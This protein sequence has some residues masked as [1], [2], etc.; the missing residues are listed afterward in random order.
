MAITDRDRHDVGLRRSRTGCRSAADDSRFRINHHSQRQARRREGQDIACIRIIEEN[1]LF[2][3][4]YA[5][6]AA[7]GSLLTTPV[8]LGWEQESSPEEAMPEEDELD[9][10][11]VAQA[12]LAGENFYQET[13]VETEKVD[14][15]SIMEAPSFRFDKDMRPSPKTAQAEP[16]ANRKTLIIIPLPEFE[17]ERK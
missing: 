9:E 7:S 2:M 10:E 11:T 15:A 13:I 12:E 6:P 3:Y 8:D 5:M 17:P 4:D 16:A 1:A 14:A